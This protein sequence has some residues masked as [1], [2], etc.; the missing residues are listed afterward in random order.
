MR[1][2][3]GFV[4]SRARV[5]AMA[6]AWIVERLAVDHPFRRSGGNPRLG[7]SL[8]RHQQRQVAAHPLAFGDQGELVAF[9]QAGQ[10]SEEEV[11]PRL[12]G[13]VQRVERL[14]PSALF[15]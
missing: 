12:P 1:T 9:R 6:R 2:A 4:A 14:G 7:P 15:M 11:S 8:H 5:A 10:G 3:S 13:A